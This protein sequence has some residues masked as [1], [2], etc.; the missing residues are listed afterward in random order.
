VYGGARVT[1][2][3]ELGVSNTT[4]NGYLLLHGSSVNKTAELFCSNGNLHIDA[5]SGNGIYMNWY[6]GTAGTL[7]GNGSA[8]QVATINGSGAAVFNTSVTT[9]TY[10]SYNSSTYF[11]NPYE[12]SNY[13]GGATTSHSA[14]RGLNFYHSAGPQMT[15]WYHASGT[16][17]GNLKIFSN[18]SGVGDCFQFTPT[19]AF[20]AKGDITAYSTTTTSDA[21]LKEN[22]RDLEGSLDKTLKLRG[23]KFDWI[24]E[25]KSKD[26]LGFIA[27]EVE[28]VI[29]EVV[30]DITNID[31]EE[32]KVVNYQA[33]VPVLVE[34]IKEL[35]AEINEL[36]EQLKNK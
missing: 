26:N 16:G 4:Q 18:S 19:G 2:N 32:H 34:A 22:V 7:F 8:G 3:L 35:K 23:V 31:G 14:R 10:Y 17:V 21:R 24:D 29:P 25:S 1:G 30:K 11:L 6:G 12:Q 20:H 13:R 5:D 28:E 36:R 9:P 33:V 15:L 27:Q